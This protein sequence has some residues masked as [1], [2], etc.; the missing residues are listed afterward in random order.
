[1]LHGDRQ[2]WLCVVTLSGDPL[3]PGGHGLQILNAQEEDGGTY[4]CVAAN[5]AG[6]AVK[7]YSVK[8]LGAG[9]LHVLPNSAVTPPL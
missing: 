2:L 3:C 8:V 5:E 4:S 1:M 6:E 9:A 7:N